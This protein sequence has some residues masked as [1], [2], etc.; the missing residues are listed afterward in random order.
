M[1]CPRCNA[2]PSVIKTEPT[3]D[4]GK[5]RLLEC[6]QHGRFWSREKLDHWVPA[7]AGQRLGNGHTTAIAVGEQ[8]PAGF[9]PIR[10]VGG[11]LPGVLSVSSPDQE[12]GYL[13]AISVD[14][15]NRARARRG[16]KAPAGFERFWAMYPRK[17]ARKKA[18]GYWITAKL[19]QDA[20]PI[21]RALQLQLPEFQETM[22]RDPS[23]V[24]HPSTWLNGERWKDEI[25]RRPRLA[26]R[27][28]RSAGNVGNLE[29]WL[30]KETA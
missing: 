24:P 11:V 18:L 28:P 16:S 15:P 26:G 4:P 3:K 23:K 9:A 13:E 2:R 14:S 21:I 30:K 29:D 5:A 19:E 22:A 27:P 12:S 8:L 25:D 10:G 20:D 1:N 6:S 17:K 7:T